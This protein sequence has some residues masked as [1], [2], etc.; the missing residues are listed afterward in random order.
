M[1]KLLQTAANYIKWSFHVPNGHEEYQM[2]PDQGVPNYT[3][4][5]SFGM[6]I[7]WQPCLGNFLLK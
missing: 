1:G 3:K 2:F 6:Q 5:C 7:N 4:I